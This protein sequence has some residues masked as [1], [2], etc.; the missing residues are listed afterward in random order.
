M[1]V[2]LPVEWAVAA[3]AVLL[4]VGMVFGG[5]ARQ[6]ADDEFEAIETGYEPTGG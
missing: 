1:T 2:E 6:C 3:A 5:L 4:V